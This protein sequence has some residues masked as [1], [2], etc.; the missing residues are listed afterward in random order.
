ML[1]LVVAVAVELASIAVVAEA[2]MQP[3]VAEALHIADNTAVGAAA[4]AE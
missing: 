3:F 2:D 1:E 4:A